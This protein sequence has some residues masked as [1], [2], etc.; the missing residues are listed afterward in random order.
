MDYTVQ[1]A[2]DMRIISGQPVTVNGAATS[3]RL[4]DSGHEAPEPSANRSAP[5]RPRGQVRVERGAK[6]IRAYLGGAVVVDSISPL[7]VWEVPY[8]PTYYFSERD[9]RADLVAEGSADLHSPSRGDATTLS[10][11]AGGSPAAGGAAR[12][13]DSP[14]D[15]LRGT[16]RVM[17][18]AMETW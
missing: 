6:R 10:V 4:D 3:G 5:P 1:G 14:I 2:N 18:D 12:Y 13:E 11:L 16:V 17:W 7:L 8:Y 15:E 9:V